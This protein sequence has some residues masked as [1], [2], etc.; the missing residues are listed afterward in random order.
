MDV[1]LSTRSEDVLLVT[2]VSDTKSILPEVYSVFYRL[3]RPAFDGGLV[4]RIEGGDLDV[5]RYIIEGTEVS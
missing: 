5:H 1:V 3:I 4:T 2:L